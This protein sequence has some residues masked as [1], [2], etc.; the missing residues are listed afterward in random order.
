VA[1]RSSAEAGGQVAGDAIKAMGEIELSSQKI[2][3]IVGMIDEIAFQ[4][5]LLALNAAVEAARAGEAGRGF[6][7]VAGEVR[8]LAQRSSQASKEIKTL[9]SN[10]NTQVKQGV[11]LVNKAGAT[12]GEIV[13]SVKRVSD[14][15]A[16][17]AAANK[18]QSASVG[19]V[20]EAIGQIEQATQQNAALV[21]E[22]T[23]ALGSADN[24]V[25]GVTDVISFFQSDAVVAARPANPPS[26][27]VKGAKAVQARL[28]AKVAK[29][30]VSPT[31]TSGGKKIAATG[32][33]D[34]WEEF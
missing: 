9:I 21:E 23:A 8:A 16:E 30:S 14:I 11:E 6:A 33:D 17:I 32:T 27:P 13:T 22:T 3:E 5:N 2:S 12:L 7:V 20:Q 4:T 1:A 10:S 19:E 18:E 28:A 34:G 26:V 15:V 24:Q 29:P 31:K 25:R